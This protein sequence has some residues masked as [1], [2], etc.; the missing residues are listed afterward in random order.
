M[1]Q[2]KVGLRDPSFINKC[3]ANQRTSYTIHNFHQ[4]HILTSVY[5]DERVRMMSGMI[6]Y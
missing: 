1:Q 5:Y 4:L 2:L 6:L 3:P